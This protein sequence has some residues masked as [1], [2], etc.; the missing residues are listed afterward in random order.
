MKKTGKKWIGVLYAAALVIMAAAG[1]LYCMM[2]KSNS[3]AAALQNQYAIE[4]GV[5]TNDD[6]DAAVSGDIVLDADAD[7]ATSDD[8]ADITFDADAGD[9]LIL[10]DIQTPAGAPADDSD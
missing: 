9:E 7:A 1:V 6:P 10:D 5:E 2:L 3:D 8:G 4:R